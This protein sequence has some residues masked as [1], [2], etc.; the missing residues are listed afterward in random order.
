MP[1]STVMSPK[2]PKS[3]IDIAKY[4]PATCSLLWLPVV[5]CDYLYM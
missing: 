1:T 2:S 5:Y 3:P 4:M